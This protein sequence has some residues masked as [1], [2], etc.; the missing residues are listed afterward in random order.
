MELF[1]RL[2]R[3]SKTNIDQ[4]LIEATNT[5]EV[6]DRIIDEIEPTLL[7]TRQEIAKINSISNEKAQLNYSAATIEASKWRLKAQIAHSNKD[8][9][10][11]KYALERLRIHEENAAE[12]KAQMHQHMDR[13]ELLKQHSNNSIEK[14][15]RAATKI[16][17][18]L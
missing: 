2:D 5:E 4:I 18:S 3:I 13:V 15:N 14:T 7:Q 16:K 17:L 1:D 6:L 11:E 9:H 12:A 10:S 8:E